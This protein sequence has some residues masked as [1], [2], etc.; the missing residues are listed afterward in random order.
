MK[1][2]FVTPELAPVAKVGG[3]ADVAASLPRALKRLGHRVYVIVPRYAGTEIDIERGRPVL[4]GVELEV[5][6]DGVRRIA[7][8][9]RARLNGVATY[10]VESDDYFDRRA[11]YGD[12]GGDYDDNPF[13]FAF[14]SRAAL[15]AT[16]AL[17]LA[18]D[19]IHVHD[20]QTAL[21]PVYQRLDG[22]S[23]RTPVV[24][25]VH[26]LAYQGIFR[27]ELLPRLGL[28]DS[29]F[30]IDAL[31]FYGGLNFLKGGLVSA[32]RLTTVSPSYARE[33]QRA[34]LGAGLEGVLR[35]RADR[36]TGI[37]NGIEPND[38]HP[39]KDPALTSRFAS[40]RLSGKAAGKLELQKELGLT[41]SPRIPL[42]AA[43]G[44]L[45]PQKGFELVLEA[46]PALVAEEKAQ[47]V[48]LGSG[49]Q[50]FLDAFRPLVAR[51]PK[52]ISVNRGFQ[53]A[54]GRRIYAY[55]D[56]FLMPSRY[57]PCGLGQMIALRYGTLPV[58]RATGGLAD[59]IRDLD[60]DPEG[61]NGFSFEA[62]DVSALRTTL[63][64]AL[65][66]Y[67]N[68]KLWTRWVRRA[69]REDSSWRSSA[70]RYLEVYGQAIRDLG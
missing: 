45:D 41:L 4:T 46:V 62:F 59:T 49:R 51:F 36:L 42:L 44:R 24:L 13:R 26:N 69:M 40:T 54:L 32:E 35:T 65:R 34:E 27:R 53:E 38:W 11:V 8:L 12:S 33:I 52:A 19:M 7:R 47:L 60:E 70:G 29:L 39:G 30:H 21:L 22:R 64:R 28:P 37:V 3:L 61:G 10:F 68:E 14:F 16:E 9:S 2:V 15:A 66:H 1:I 50:E 31:E 23:S 55:A 5:E 6:M 18:P 57:E 43:I 17:G 67:E 58:V 63:R 25:T 56:L 20:W 48:V